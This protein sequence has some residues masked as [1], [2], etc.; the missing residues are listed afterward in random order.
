M[1]SAADRGVKLAA[2]KQPVKIGTIGQNLRHSVMG[3]GKLPI[4]FCTCEIGKIISSHPPPIACHSLTMLRYSYREQLPS[5]QK[6]PLTAEQRPC[7][8]Y[9]MYLLPK[10]PLAL[11]L[12][13]DPLQSDILVPTNNCF[14]QRHVCRVMLTLLIIYVP[15][16][17]SA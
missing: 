9:K 2:R 13:S 7:S 5:N 11:G 17:S 16:G 6:P 10:R 15:V 3:R 4:Q 8:A 12:L 14:A 1:P